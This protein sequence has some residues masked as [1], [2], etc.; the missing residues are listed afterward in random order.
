MLGGPSKNSTKVRT[1]M[2]KLLSKELARAVPPWTQVL[3]KTTNKDVTL[4]VLRTAPS[5]PL[6]AVVVQLD[7]GL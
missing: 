6:S 2:V 7:F 4:A 1:Y 5:K 3:W